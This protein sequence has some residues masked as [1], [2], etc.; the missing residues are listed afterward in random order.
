[1][2]STD[3]TPAPATSTASAALPLRRRGSTQQ[4]HQGEGRFGS[5]FG[6]RRKTGPQE[7]RGQRQGRKQ[8]QHSSPRQAAR[9]KPAKGTGTPQDISFEALVDKNL[10]KG[11]RV[12]RSSASGQRTNVTSVST[13]GQ[14]H[15]QEENEQQQSLMLLMDSPRNRLPHTAQGGHSTPSG[16]SRKYTALN[17][18]ERM[19]L[20]DN[21]QQPLSGRAF[22]S[23]GESSSCPCRPFWL[24]F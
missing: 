13:T 18:A 5:P 16:S 19:L 24:N 8:Q 10:G 2:V 7:Q 17:T 12:A 1:M 11:W 3:V 21:S 4:Q 15:H 22:D 14:Q 9:P 6:S 20:T 23:V